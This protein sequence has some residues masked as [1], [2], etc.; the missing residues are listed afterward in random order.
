[1]QAWIDLFRQE[2]TACT[3]LCVAATLGLLFAIYTNSRRGGG[4]E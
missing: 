4:N 3:G 1:M 2:P